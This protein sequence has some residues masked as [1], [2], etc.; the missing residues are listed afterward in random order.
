[1]WPE[2]Y[3]EEVFKITISYIRDYFT[4]PGKMMILIVPLG[5]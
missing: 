1:M 5:L 2:L 4:L 3:V